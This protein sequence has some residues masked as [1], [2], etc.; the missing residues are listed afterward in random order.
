M[1]F[2]SRAYLWDSWLTVRD[3]FAEH[4]PSYALTPLEATYLVWIDCR[5][6]GISSDRLCAELIEAGVALSSG[7][8][9]GDDS[10]LRLNIACPRSRLS[11]GLERI[12]TVLSK[13]FQTTI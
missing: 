7:S 6:T 11:Q 5:H 2:R 4:L 9:Y 3:F 13:Y 12:R 10:F 8:I 1:L